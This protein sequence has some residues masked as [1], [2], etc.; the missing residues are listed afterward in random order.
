MDEHRQPSKGEIRDPEKLVQY[1]TSLS[2]AVNICLVETAPHYINSK[3]NAM[4]AT[5]HL[6]RFH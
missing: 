3:D 1:V 5:M 2:P 4:V 6:M